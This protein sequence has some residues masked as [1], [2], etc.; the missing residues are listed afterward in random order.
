[1]SGS[2]NASGME[3]ASNA[4]WM[5]TFADLLSLMLTF[6]VLVFSMSTIQF[7]SW[8]DVVGTMR[9]EFNPNYRAIT[10][11]RFDNTQAVARSSIPGLN[12][13]Y[14]M[15]LIERD[16]S[17]NAGLEDAT[18][19]REQD[20]VIIS[21]PASRLFENKTGRFQTG[22]PDILA[23]LAGSL[24]QIKNKLMIASHTND[25]PV[26]N[27]RF[28]SNW[29]LSVTRAQL[30]AGVLVD[31]G[32]LQPVTVL[33]HGDSKFMAKQTGARVTV[34]EL[35]AQERIDFVILG[36]SRTNGILDVF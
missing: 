10:D 19:K 7:D 14:L 12:L 8:K 35:D 22:A 1:M 6:F 18:V 17:R 34:Q 36:E 3:G 27:G 9:D 29:E 16:L 13:N 15:T 11:R 4:G 32:Y 25:L 26:S 24:L 30:V 28:R 2:K 5:L 21:V 20:R 23:E 31:A 33:G